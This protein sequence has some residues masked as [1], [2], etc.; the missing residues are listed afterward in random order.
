[1]RL[2][3]KV[4]LLVVSLVAATPIAVAQGKESAA[5]GIVQDVAWLNP[6]NNADTQEQLILRQNVRFNI[7]R[8]IDGKPATASRTY[9]PNGFRGGMYSSRR[10]TSFTASRDSS[11]T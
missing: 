6:M 4:S 8:E 1:M 3:S 2:S 7:H 11:G 5:I 10:E 9:P